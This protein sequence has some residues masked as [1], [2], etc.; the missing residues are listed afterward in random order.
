MNDYL[1]VTEGCKS[2]K[3]EEYVKKSYHIDEELAF[4]ILLKERSIDL[5]A[6][7]K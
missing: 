1:T 2:I 6:K 4:S 3:F 7:N 5:V